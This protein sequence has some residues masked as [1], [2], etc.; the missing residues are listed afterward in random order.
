MPVRNRQTPPQPSLSERIAAVEEAY[1]FMLAYAS[2]GLTDESP[3]G[4]ENIRAFL[5]QLA[6][7]LG[8]ISEAAVAG[9]PEEQALQAFAQLLEGSVG[10]ALVAIRLVLATPS[11]GSQL[12]DNLNA[13]IHLRTL[14]TDLFL[15]EEAIKRV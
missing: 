8:G 15:V 12:I 9:A 10:K 2:R 6:D 13:S 5:E 14:L 3:A 11:I 1:E 4:G 7:A